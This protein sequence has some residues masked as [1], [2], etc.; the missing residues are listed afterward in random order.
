[1]S[2]LNA[3]GTIK[4]LTKQVLVKELVAA[5]KILDQDLD[6]MKFKNELNSTGKKDLKVMHTAMKSLQ[7]ESA[8]IAK[9]W[10]WTEETEDQLLD[11]R[12][13]KF[14]K[15]FNGSKSTAQR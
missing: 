2:T 15:V 4:A 7:P 13:R 11:L 1:M 12:N 9:L 14:A 10:K 6:V 8:P 5:R 3:S